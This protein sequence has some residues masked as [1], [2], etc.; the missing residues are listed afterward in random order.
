MAF[1]GRTRFRRKRPIKSRY[2]RKRVSV[3]RR[4]RTRSRAALRGAA[5]T[6][7]VAVTS[8]ISAFGANAYRSET[9]LTPRQVIT[10]AVTNTPLATAYQKVRLR[11][12][13]VTFYGVP[14][15]STQSGVAVQS[16]GVDLAGTPAL[17]NGQTDPRFQGAKPTT[18]IAPGFRRLSAYHNTVKACKERDVADWLTL[19]AGVLVSTY[20]T[21]I[22]G[23]LHLYFSGLTGGAVPVINELGSD[24]KLTLFVTFYLEFSGVRTRL[25][26]EP[27]V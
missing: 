27:D 16:M 2:R 8:D 17:P 7:T 12:F 23:I 24:H 15:V 4:I 20:P 18:R 10:A 26:V 6:R 25:G 19:N 3:K 14:P 5:F 13:R 21:D 22:G 1:R 9:L 11:G